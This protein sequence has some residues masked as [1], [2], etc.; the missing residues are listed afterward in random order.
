MEYRAPPLPVDL[1]GGN[2]DD[3][4]LSVDAEGDKRVSSANAANAEIM[5]KDADAKSDLFRSVAQQR[6]NI[7]F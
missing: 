1:A 5:E 7:F 3:G 6:H 2:L 4:K